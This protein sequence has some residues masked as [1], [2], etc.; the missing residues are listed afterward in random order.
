M[1]LFARILAAKVRPPAPVR[2]LGADDAA[3]AKV[4]LLE[5]QRAAPA[6]PVRTSAPGPGRFVGGCKAVNA[7]TG[8]RCQLL[9]GHAGAHCHGR[10]AF[11]VVAAPGQTRFAAREAIDTAA[12]SRPTSHQEE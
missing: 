6:V 4:V 8:H 12:H 11:T 10:T 3:K 1:S 9:D 2:Q 5:L 7:H